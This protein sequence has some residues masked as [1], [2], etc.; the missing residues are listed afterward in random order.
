MS[1]LEEVVAA[2]PATA[3]ALAIFCRDQGL[4]PT[5]G[6]MYIAFSALLAAAWGEG[7]LE[8]ARDV[9]TVACAHCD[10]RELIIFR[11][12]YA[13]RPEWLRHPLW[14]ALGVELAGAIGRFEAESLAEILGSS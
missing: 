2:D 8:A 5:R 9:L 12:L 1:G 14:T 10:T 4:N 3:K 6:P 7:D 13:E 11:D